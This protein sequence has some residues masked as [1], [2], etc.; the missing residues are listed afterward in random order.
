VV[1]EIDR[2]IDEVGLDDVGL[3]EPELRHADVGDVG[4]GSGLDVVDADHA[5]TAAQQLVAEM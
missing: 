4:E 3:H 1:D 2:F 5:M